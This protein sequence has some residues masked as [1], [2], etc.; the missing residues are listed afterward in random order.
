MSFDLIKPY[1]DHFNKRGFDASAH[2]QF[3]IVNQANKIPFFLGDRDDG[4]MM[5]T[6][7]DL[8]EKA[9]EDV[10]TLMQ[11]IELLNRQSRFAKFYLRTD[12]DKS[13]LTISAWLPFPY[14]VTGF[15]KAYALWDSDVNG[16]LSESE[17]AQNFLVQLS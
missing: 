17:F 4:L 8:T 11:W 5:F 15:S 6:A 14:E 10:F 2:G 13:A 1:M 12:G 7:L 9:H 3:A 16:H